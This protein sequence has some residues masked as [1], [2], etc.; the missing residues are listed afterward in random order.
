MFFMI[1]KLGNSHDVLDGPD[2]DVVHLHG[3][4]LPIVLLGVP[5]RIPGTLRVPEI[6]R[7]LIII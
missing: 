5:G 6:K 3:R 7:S 1:V 2:L 4:L